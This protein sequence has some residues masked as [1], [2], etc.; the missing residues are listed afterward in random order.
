MT[1]PSRNRLARFLVATVAA[2]V[3]PAAA[4]CSS[5]DPVRFKE[6]DRSDSAEETSGTAFA[7][8]TLTPEV[9][10]GA[11]QLTAAAETIRKRATSAGLVVKTVTVRDGVLVARVSSSKFGAD[12]RQ[13]LAAI[14]GV[15]QLTVRPVNSVTPFPPATG[16]PGSGTTPTGGPECGDPAAPKADPPSAEVVVCDGKLSEKYVLGPAVL[17]R[18]DIAGAEARTTEAG[19]FAW[20]VIVKWTNSGQVTFTRLTSEAAGG[21]LPTDRIAIVCDGRLLVAPSVRSAIPG[22]VVISGTFNEAEARQL[23]GTIDG[24]VLPTGFKVDSYVEGR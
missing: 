5:E 3:L 18:T 14:V 19:T 16:G 24:G 22:E 13:R 6:G 4:G 7:E 11:P 17:T 12:T 20:T 23:A 8:A 1:Q 10:L 2:A 15:G 21:R 9:P